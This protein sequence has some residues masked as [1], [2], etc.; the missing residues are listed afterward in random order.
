[1]A[2][3]ALNTAFTKAIVTM[4]EANRWQK[5]RTKWT[6]ENMRDL[7]WTVIKQQVLPEFG[8]RGPKQGD[9]PEAIK[10]MTENLLNAR[11]AFDKAFDD[12]YTLESSNCGKHLLGN[13][14][15]SATS[16]QT[17]DESLWV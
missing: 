17:T 6:W 14:Y 8:I 2:K 9:T 3:P 16:E 13:G 1:M 5:N 12:G 7:A 10:E 11:K 4:I 15:M